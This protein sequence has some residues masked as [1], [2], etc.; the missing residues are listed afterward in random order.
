[1]MA[2]YMEFPTLVRLAF[3]ALRLNMLRS[4]LTTLGIVIGVAMVI[5]MGAIGSDARQKVEDQI[6]LFGV[7]VLIAIPT[8][9]ASGGYRGR[10]VTLLDDDIKAIKERLLN[11][12]AVTGVVTNPVTLVSGNANWS[13]NLQ[14]VDSDYAKVYNVEMREGR[15]FDEQDNRIGAK[16]VVLSAT[17]A[18]KLFNESS[19]IDKIVR[20]AGIPM[21]VIGVRISQGQ[22]AG[23]D[24]DDEVFVPLR[25]A[26]SRLGREGDSTPEKLEAIGV[27]IAPG[28]D[29]S[30]AQR[31]LTILLRERKHIPF[32]QQDIFQVINTEKFVQLLNATQVTLSWLVGAAAAISLIVG[33]V[34][35]MNIMLVSVTERTREIGLRLAVGARKSHILAQFLTEAIVLSLFGAALGTATGVALVSVATAAVGRTMIVGAGLLGV[36]TASSVGV[37]LIFGYFPARRA[38]SLNPIDALRH[39]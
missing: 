22:L 37:G 26:R 15:F 33:G 4:L 8:P 34:G 31:D 1:M 29:L 3:A 38:A 23:Q 5:V 17:V 24:L 25:T 2:A 39:E 32:G 27:K 19:S 16:V 12:E 36:A 7:D 20:I 11:V 10:I 6:R 21:K 18:D 28:S 35:I 9:A 13:T 14:G 30:D